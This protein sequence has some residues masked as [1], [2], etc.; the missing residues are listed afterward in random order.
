MR[1]GEGGQVDLHKQQ[2]ISIQLLAMHLV[3]ISFKKPLVM[4]VIY[5]EIGI[6]CH[7][8]G[9]RKYYGLLLFTTK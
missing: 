1:D 2:V 5:I 7:A 8:V 3:R 9:A 6:E 4:L